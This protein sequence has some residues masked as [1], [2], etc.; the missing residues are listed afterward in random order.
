MDIK[1]CTINLV[2]GSYNPHI[3]HSMSCAGSSHSLLAVVRVVGG[4][5]VEGLLGGPWD[6]VTTH[7]RGAYNLPYNP[8][9]W[10]YRGYPNYK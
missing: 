3:T 10:A 6:L 4:I 8:S 5:H 2:Q 1:G 9:T 7:N